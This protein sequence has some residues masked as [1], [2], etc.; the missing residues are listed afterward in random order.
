M[1]KLIVALF[2]FA[3]TLLATS[4][5][6]LSSPTGNADLPQ[7]GD[8][9]V[10]VHKFQLAIW[11]LDAN[12]VKRDGD[13]ATAVILVLFNPVVQKTVDGTKVSANAGRIAVNC[14]A[15]TIKVQSSYLMSEDGKIIKQLP[16]DPGFAAYHENTP[17]EM[18]AGILCG[19][20]KTKPTPNE[21]DI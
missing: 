21:T 11:A 15:K 19:T 4:A 2:A 5:V 17:A 9:M 7:N 18:I 8:H 13:V 6:A 1:K 10:V 16:G 20:A 12:S 3:L 14:T